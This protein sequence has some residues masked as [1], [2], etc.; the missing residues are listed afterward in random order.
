MRFRELAHRAQI[1]LPRRDAAHVARDRLDDDGG[2]FVAMLVHDFLQRVDV[3]VRHGQRVLRRAFRD[4]RRARHAERRHAA[5]RVDEQAVAVAVI[6]ADEFQN[7]VASRVAARE[8]QSAHRGLR[9]GIDHAD[10]LDG[11]IDA[12]HELRELA[13]EQRRRA[14]A[15]AARDGLLQ[16]FHD[17]RMG[18][19][20]DHRTPGAD[21]VDVFVAVDVKD[22]VAF[23]AGD[24]R[25]VAVDVRIGADRAVDAARHE[26]FRLVEGGEGFRKVKHGFFLQNQ[27]SSRSHLA[28]SMA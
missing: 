3:V 11:G 9:A 6:A 26:V 22:A 10:H 15:R 2:D 27:F 25:R 28:A 20:D 8:T 12:L 24:E 23:G 13:F 18:M 4:A 16:G 14:V 19:A 5:A 21:I 1:P 17:I 7:L